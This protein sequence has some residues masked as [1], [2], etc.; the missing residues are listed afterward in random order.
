[1]QCTQG[2]HLCALYV[3]MLDVYGRKWK[4]RGHGEGSW[5]TR[6]A[7]ARLEPGL[8]SRSIV[9]HP[10]VLGGYG[11]YAPHLLQ[12]ILRNRPPSWPLWLESQSYRVRSERILD[13][14]LSAAAKIGTAEG[15]LPAESLSIIRFSGSGFGCLTGVPM[16]DC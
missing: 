7:C 15:E 8:R 3:D 10:W 12:Y 4:D 2:Q 5:C 1:M 11:L 16:W 14:R 6:A 9:A 13:G